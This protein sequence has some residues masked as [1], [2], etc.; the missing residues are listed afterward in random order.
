MKNIFNRIRSYLQRRKELR[1]LS[2][3]NVVFTILDTETTGLSVNEGHKILSIGAVKI[4][5]N[6]IIENEILDELINPERDIPFA[7]RNI[8]YITEDKIKDKPNIYQ[9]EKKINDFIERTILVGHNID[10]DIGFIKKN[11]AKTSLAGTIKKI[12]SIDT[13]LLSAGL[14]PSLE[15]YELSFLCDQFRIKTFD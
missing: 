4:K 5:N 8:H 14:F 9:L 13:I 1:E 2:I 6:L 15:S 11:A 3:D 12:T 7:S 10:F